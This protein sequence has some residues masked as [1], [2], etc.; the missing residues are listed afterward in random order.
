MS[1]STHTAVNALRIILIKP[2][3]YDDE[4]Y[5]IRHWKGTLP[6]NTLA[7]LQSLTDSVRESG[8]LGPHVEIAT[9]LWDD[10]VHR[11]R[12][13]KIMRRGAGAKTVVCLCGVQ[14]NQ[15]PRASDLAKTFRALGAD[16][17]IGGFHVS[18]AIAMSD[19]TPPEIQ[20]LIDLGVTVV[21]GEIEDSW[22]DI[23]R[24]AHAGT[25]QPIYSFIES[26][27]D[28][29]DQPIPMMPR[30]YRRRFTFKHMAT[31]D[32][33]RGCPFTC[34]FCTVINVQGRKMRC[35]SPE[36]IAQSIRDNWAQG[37]THYFF[38]DDNLARNKRWEE[39][40]DRMIEMRER[41][42]I[43]L[44]FMMQVDTQSHRIPRFI[45]K[46]RRAGCTQVFIGV[47]SLNPESL[48]D[49]GKGQNHTDQYAELIQAWREAEVATHTAYIIGFDHDTRESVLDHDLEKLIHELEPDQASFFMLT[50][51]P[52]SEDHARWRREG[53][54]MAADLNIYD[55]F[56]ASM[57]H[58]RMSEEEWTETYQE[59]WQRFYSFENMKAIL[60][61]SSDRNYWNVMKNFIWYRNAM[62]EGEHAMI[63]GFFRRKSRLDRRPGFPI[64]G[65]WAFFKRRVCEISHLLKEWL[66]LYWEMQELWLATWPQRD[67]R[68][69]MAKRY[70]VSWRDILRNFKNPLR[71]PRVPT[72]ISM[73]FALL[74]RKRLLGRGQEAMALMRRR[75]RI[76][77]RMLNLYWRQTLKRFGR[78]QWHRIDVGK[79]ILN[80][81]RE[82]KVNLWFMAHM[83]HSSRLSAVGRLG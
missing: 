7:A 20:E 53:R 67:Q 31:V 57:P 78:L 48:R 10:T 16:V 4:G 25:L 22:A 74:G 59:S 60:Q 13:E 63:T 56:H 28:L 26:K 9:E 8:A 79:T 77:R 61:R 17:M 1:T 58:P 80:G 51:L 43:K 82:I 35:R 68:V 50:P 27:P 52:G 29:T 46:A 47:E 45:E 66:K 34:S 39:L 30:S 3:K 75:A 18:G 14:S 37:V 19:A 5:V 71:W 70:V 33:S 24:D 72:Q 2:S 81:W 73:R 32:T 6:S 11:I 49:A 12:P 40:F 23:L 55:S 76:S 38:V 69:Q 64:Q 41:E 44:T 62:I 54:P 15:F 83:A 21:V 65:R 42:G 36:R